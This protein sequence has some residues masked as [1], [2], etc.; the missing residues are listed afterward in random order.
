M[1]RKTNDLFNVL[2]YGNNLGAHKILKLVC[3]Q[4]KITLVDT[5]NK[6][7]LIAYHYKIAFIGR[8][9]L[10]NDLINTLNELAEFENPGDWDIVIFGGKPENI[11]APLRMYCRGLNNIDEVAI[12]KIIDKHLPKNKLHSSSKTKEDI[13]QK[14]IYRIVFLY[15]LI[16]QSGIISKNQLCEE[17]G[18]TERT[19]FRDL[20]V[21]R[22]LFPDQRFFF[23]KKPI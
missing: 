23:E 8:E 12:S 2:F 18:I 21:I 7:D 11:P 3:A 19:L 4:K 20:K 6:T 9:L 15:H 17:F 14:R 22:E 10:D 1:K 16:N 13:F 5:K